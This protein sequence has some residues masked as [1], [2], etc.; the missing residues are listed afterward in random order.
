M[1]DPSSAHLTWPPPDSDAAKA[2]H[3]LRATSA[4]AQRRSGGPA[5]EEVFARLAT[6]EAVP[7]STW[8][9]TALRT[10]AEAPAMIIRLDEHARQAVWR[11]SGHSPTIQNLLDRF[12]TG[13]CGPVALALASTHGDGRVRED[14]VARIVA[15]PSPGLVPFLVLRTADWVHPVRNRARAGLVLLLRD[16]P[17]ALPDALGMMLRLQTRG[18]GGFAHAQALAA[19]HACTPSQRTRIAHSG[20]PTQR[21]FWFRAAIGNEWLTWDDLFRMATDDHDVTI[22]ATAAEATARQAVW[23]GRVATLTR[24]A[25][26]HHD[27]VRPVGLTGLARLGHHD[28][29]TAH[30]DDN[31]PLVRALARRSAEHLGID[32]VTHY[33]EHV[34]ALNAGRTLADPP[35]GAT[36][37]APTRRVGPASRSARLT[38]L[39]LGAIAGLAETTRSDYDT[40]LL[41]ELLDHP[42]PKIRA[43]ALR[44]LRQLH[45]TPTPRVIDLLNDPSPKV[46]REATDA[47]LATTPPVPEALATTMLTTSTRV[48]LR[49]AGYRL[50]RARALPTRLRAAL[51]LT[52]DPDPA[53][54]N[55]GTADATALTRAATGHAWRRTWDPT[56]RVTVQELAD[57]TDLAHRASTRLTED[58]ATRL[59]TWLARTRPTG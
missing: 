46:V 55:R 59:Q 12:R 11:Y 28:Q 5:V 24:L 18:R 54:A 7:L 56:L 44:A 39:G 2:L 50:L 16:Q 41:S 22:R 33:R 37:P 38:A 1:P 51:I 30:L 34:A 3:E 45:A 26:S 48:E 52:T 9:D 10:V 25:A 47:L 57:L 49:R 23:T 27:D 20:D 13:R 29:V 14:A 15:S 42:Q 40:A 21:R 31:Q 19:L 32:P 43:G 53:L 6:F 58:T 17:E 35:A 36:A 8:A 4:A